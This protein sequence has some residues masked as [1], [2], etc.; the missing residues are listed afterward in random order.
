MSF[1][2]DDLACMKTRIPSPTSISLALDAK[3]IENTKQNEC[4][5]QQVQ[6]KAGA[7]SLIY[8]HEQFQLVK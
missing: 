7:A 5:I 4:L 6:F 3:K 2:W 8:F 1:D